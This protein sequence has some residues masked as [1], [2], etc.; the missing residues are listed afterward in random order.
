M[1]FQQMFD[2]N[3]EQSGVDFGKVP[4]EFMMSH[5]LVFNVEHKENRVVHPEPRN[6]NT[7]VGAYK[8]GAVAECA[9]KMPYIITALE[10]LN[11]TELGQQEGMQNKFNTFNTFISD[12][13][14]AQILPVDRDEIIK[15]LDE[16]GVKL[17]GPAKIA[18]FSGSNL[19]ESP[20]IKGLLVG[21]DAYC[22]GIMITI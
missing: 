13:R 4:L 2:Q 7:L 22:P 9:S 17:E 5:V 16:F 10:Q 20:S 21:M 6:K 19:A 12:L 14:M 3:M 18:A 15:S 1:S 8:L 11:L